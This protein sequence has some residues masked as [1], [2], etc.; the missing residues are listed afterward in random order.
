MA[1]VSLGDLEM[2]LLKPSEALDYY[3]EASEIF[4]NLINRSD[5]PLFRMHLGNV[6]DK[7][8]KAMLLVGNPSATEA[9]D[10]AL[11]LRSSSYSKQHDGVEFQTELAQ[12]HCSLGELQ[13]NR[14][15]RSSARMSRNRLT[16]SL[17]PSTIASSTFP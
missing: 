2:D 4:E 15:E 16:R 8:G 1:Q 14:D 6:Y 13:A 5:T 7:I 10:R 17:G 12:A 9:F 3:Q 11:Q